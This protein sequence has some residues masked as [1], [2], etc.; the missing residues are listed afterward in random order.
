MFLKRTKVRSGKNVYTYLQLVESVWKDGRPTHRVVAN[1]GRED[2]LDPAQIDRLV[3]S[4]AAYGSGE[5]HLPASVTIHD[6]REYGTVHVLNHLWRQFGCDD[7][8]RSLARERS[9]SFDIEAAWRALVFARICAPGSERSVMRWLP[10]VYA[11]EFEGLQLQHLYRTLD[12]VAEVK[13]EFEREWLL[14]LTKTLCPDLRLVLFDTTSVYFEGAGPEGLAAYGYSRDKR[15][16]LPQIVLGLFTTD[17]GYPLTHVVFPGNAIDLSVFREAMADLRGKLPISEIVMVMDRGMVSEANLRMLDELGIPYIVGARLRQLATREVLKTA[18]RYRVVAENLQVKD[19]RRDGVRYVICYNPQEAERDQAERASMVAYLEE[20]LRGGLKAFVKN[21]AAKRY[22]KVRGE[23][24][25]L[26]QARI[27]DDARYDGK[28]VLQTSTELDAAQVAL[29]YKGLW[30]VE[31]A[32]R[33]LKNPLEIR[34]VYHWTPRRVR[35]HVALCVHAYF[36]ERLVENR[37]SQARLDLEPGTVWD[38]LRRI[39]ATDL[40]LG[41]KRLMHCTTLTD[42]QRRL[43][44]ALEVPEPERIL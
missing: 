29:A 38:E 28:W 32:F 4:L 23:Q 40:Q 34:P 36:F 8:V 17:E 25:T 22:L 21:P 11:P 35:A 7:L 44:Q 15:S 37:I 9:F 20:R 41:F 30:Q 33:T 27:R 1:L 31:R 3:A 42:T 12:F 24:I 10:G 2:K 43:L 26:D 14:R 19:V 5:V 39:R 13:D 6:A 18:G 16:D